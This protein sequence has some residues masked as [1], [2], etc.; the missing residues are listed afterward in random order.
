MKSR[1]FV[2]IFNPYNVPVA[3]MNESSIPHFLTN[4]RTWLTRKLT[5]E[6]AEA[7]KKRRTDSE[8]NPV[9]AHMP[10][11]PNLSSSE[12]EIRKKSIE[13]LKV[14]ISLAEQLGID[15]LV[16]HLGSH[17]GHGYTTLFPFIIICTG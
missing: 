14:N 15:Y 12:K 17:M 8:I 1:S 9:I 2:S 6:E 4:P 16:L 5:A 7:F 10:Y 3:S 13:S 11:L